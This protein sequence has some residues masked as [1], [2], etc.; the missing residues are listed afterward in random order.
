MI[1]H[2]YV[3]VTNTKSAVTTMDPPMS[4]TNE[5]VDTASCVGFK[6]RSGEVLKKRNREILRRAVVANS[7]RDL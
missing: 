5:V 2:T 3:G 7:E 6:H 1:P 4:V